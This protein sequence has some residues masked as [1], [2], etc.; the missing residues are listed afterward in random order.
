MCINKIHF[1]MINS[2]KRFIHILINISFN[3]REEKKLNTKFS[4]IFFLFI[5]V[6]LIIHKF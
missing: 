2:V 6:Q 3:F 5:Q 4:F 1:F